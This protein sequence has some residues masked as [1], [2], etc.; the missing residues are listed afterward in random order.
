[1]PDEGVCGDFIPFF[2]N[3]K[4]YLFYLYHAKNFQ[5]YGEGIPWKLIET[6]DFITFFDYGEVLPH[7]T[8]NDQDLYC[9]TGSVIKA[10]D[11]YHIFYTGHNHNLKGKGKQQVILHAVSLDMKHWEKKGTV[12]CADKNKL[13]PDDFRD[14][15][16]FYDNTEQNFKMLVTGRKKGKGFFSGVTLCY[17]SEDLVN[18]VDRGVFW[19]PDLYYT[20]E[21]PDLFKLGDWWYLI[22]SEDMEQ[23]RTKYVMSHSLGG[24]WLIPADDCFDGCAFYAAKTAGYENKRYLFGWIAAADEEKDTSPLVWGGNLAVH[25][26]QQR[27]DGTLTVKI[28]ESLCQAG[29]TVVGKRTELSITA[30]GRRNQILLTKNIQESF[31]F[32]C[33]IIPKT[34]KAFGIYLWQDENN[35]NGYKYEFDVS[36]NRLKFDS[37]P[38]SF[39]EKNLYRKINLSDSP[40]LHIRIIA[41]KSICIMYVNDEIALSGRCYER[42]GNNISAFVI[43]GDI[44]LP[45]MTLYDLDISL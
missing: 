12:L 13:E 4:F 37:I 45:E 18:W 20:H 26:L 7:G 22:Y 17:S 35:K 41:D 33:T 3:N 2:E 30:K 16:V 31:I 36:E 11:F 1:M 14:P 24:E 27:Q 39:K 32:E 9:F 15:F 19:G 38:H 29:K 10:S 42:T 21:C 23:H 25:E 28:P 43:D 40:V 44:Q 6:K 8:I 5:K 34:D